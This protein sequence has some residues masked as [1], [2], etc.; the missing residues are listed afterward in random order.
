MSVATLLQPAMPGGVG[1]PL[2]EAVNH[3]IFAGDMY[4]ALPEDLSQAEDDEA[5][6]R[7]CQHPEDVLSNWATPA[8]TLEGALAA[9]RLARQ[10]HDVADGDSL[11]SSLLRAGLGY[12]GDRGSQ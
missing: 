1:D 4:D 9:L 5:F 6:C 12:F 7:L 8:A 3:F 10:L 11:V 2:L